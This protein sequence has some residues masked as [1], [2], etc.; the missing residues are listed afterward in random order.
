MSRKMTSLCRRVCL[1]L[2]ALVAIEAAGEVTI[3]YEA[4]LTANAG[5]YTTAPYYIASNRDGTL[6]QRYSVLASAA[7]WHSM[8][9][10]RRLSYGFGAELWGGY[11]SS[12]DYEKWDAQAGTMVTNPQHPARVWVQQAYVEGKYRGV[13]A[14][15]GARRLA[16]PILNTAL[17]SGD[18]IMS[19]NA[20]PPIGAR[21]GFV[22]FQNIPFTRGWVQITGEM[23]YYRLGDGKWLENHYNYYNNYV[24][25]GY[26]FN[27]KNIYFRTNPTK[28]FVF[29]IG[30]QASCQFAGDQRFYEKGVNTSTVKMDLN[31]KAF[32]R[33][34]V[35]GSGGGNSGDHFVEGN[36]VGTWDVILQYRFKGGHVIKGY[37]QRLWEDGSGIGWCNGWDGLYGIEYAAP[38][39]S[40]VSGAVVE[41]IDFTNQS[42]SIH[43]APVD[44]EGTALTD[45]ATGADDYYNNYSY[46]GYHNHGMSIGS[47][48]VKS[49][50]Y[51]YNGVMRYSDNMMRGFHAGITG[52][53]TSEL[54][55]RLLGSYRKSWGRPFSPRAV[56]LDD[57]S[58]LV[59]AVYAPARVAG[60]RITAQ[61]G[62]DRGDLY[63]DNTGGLVSVSYHG[64][65]TL[66]K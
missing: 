53:I 3:D 2:L 25:T 10:T 39:R 31:A 40:I 20:R 50:L 17:S 66:G 43:W 33:A 35:A 18:L 13:M 6:T 62:I 63:H 58:L 61:L 16:S 64:N 4:S 65:L 37:H 45:E 47:P 26:W 52:Y 1:P 27:Y 32:F 54:Q 57:T 59:E 38:G 60:L 19:A 49:P 21:A 56:P 12:T 34:L 23:G 14:S 11:A 5:S 8:D 48:F 55:Y 9:T 51:N 24:T 46:N 36:H 7:A 29:T 28:P 22:N 44:H 41:Y 30:A 15:V 42:G